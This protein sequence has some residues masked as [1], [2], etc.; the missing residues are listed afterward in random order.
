MQTIR[1]FASRHFGPNHPEL[2]EFIESLKQSAIGQRLLDLEPESPKHTAKEQ[3]P[4]HVEVVQ[5]VIAP[6]ADEIRCQALTYM[7]RPNERG[8]LVPKQCIR[9]KESGSCF[10]KQHNV[11]VNTPCSG[12]SMNSGHD[13]VHKYQWEHFGTIAQPTWVFEK[14][15]DELK[16]NYY[17]TLEKQRKTTHATAKTVCKKQVKAIKPVS[18]KPE[19]QVVA[20]TIIP[21]EVFMGLRQLSMTSTQDIVDLPDERTFNQKLNVW[22]DDDTQLYFTTEKDEEPVGQVIRDKLVP[23]R[24]K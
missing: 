16:A 10:C 18:S 1:E 7:V 14:Y 23:F 5:M 4:P 21:P 15:A 19:V 20:Q 22:I 17:K 3:I 9:A 6:K 24:R 12:C 13:I 2:R 11:V 8:I